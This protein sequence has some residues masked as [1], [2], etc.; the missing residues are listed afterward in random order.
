MSNRLLQL[1]DIH[2]GGENKPAAEAA[3][4]FAHDYAPLLT[5]VTGDLT[6]NGLPDEFRAGM[7]WYDRLPEPRVIT[8]GNHDTPYWNIPARAFFPFDRYKRFVGDPD[9]GAFDSSALGLRMINTSRGAQ[10][11]P[12]WSKGAIK[13]ELCVKVA[14]DLARNDPGALKVVGVHHPLIEAEGVPV[15]GG[16]YRGA[17]AA[18]LLA[19]GGVDL[20]LSGHVH[21]PFAVAMPAGDHFTYAVGAGTL[22]ER[23]RGTPASFNTIE[24]DDAEVRVCAHGWT[25]ERFEPFRSWSLPRRVRRSAAA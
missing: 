5:A 16:V 10:P 20:I 21:N 17:E 22:S 9:G 23:L 12:D 4:A 14:A 6:L 13:L 24:W 19:E 11:R 25:G 15:T 7:A 18:R 1:S 2:F 8:P 3:L